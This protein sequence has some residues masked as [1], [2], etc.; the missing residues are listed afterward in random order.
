MSQR[1]K[2]K[3]KGK[4]NKKS[5]ILIFTFA[6]DLPWFGGRKKR[7]K[8]FASRLPCQSGTPTCLT[9]AQKEKKKNKGEERNVRNL[10]ICT[11]FYQTFYPFYSKKKATKV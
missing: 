7:K 2:E 8:I 4:K 6:K 10:L 3:K 5:R 9:L 11:V 1:K